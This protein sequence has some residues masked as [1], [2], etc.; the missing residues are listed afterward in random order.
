MPTNAS[1]HSALRRSKKPSGIG[2]QPTLL[3]PHRL[4]AD[5]VEAIRL[6]GRRVDHDH[7]PQDGEVRVY[8]NA[9]GL[10]ERIGYNSYTAKEVAAALGERYASSAEEAC[11]GL[12]YGT[13][14]LD[15]DANTCC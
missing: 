3:E 14:D 12:D 4:V 2:A 6:G 7:G 9:G 5:V 11:A 10:T 15:P 8:D 1:S 13:H